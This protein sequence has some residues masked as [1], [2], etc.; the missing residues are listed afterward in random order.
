MDLY[1]LKQHVL[2][3]T[4]KQDN[5][6]D[7]YI[8][9]EKLTTISRIH[10]GACLSDH[11]N[12]TWTQKVEKQQMEKIN[13]TSRNLK[14]INDQNFAS[15]LAEKNSQLN[16]IDNLQTLYEVYIEAITSTLDQHVPEITKKI[17]KRQQKSWYDRDAL[18][19]K[20]T[21]KHCRKNWL[22]TKKDSELENYLYRERPQ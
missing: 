15:D 19:L 10:E 16:S 17:T 18:K 14:S 11:C 1:G 13:H 8:S 22:K 7:Y 4:Y 2:I 21:M 12:I 20:K 5:T 9:K 6:L 3:Q